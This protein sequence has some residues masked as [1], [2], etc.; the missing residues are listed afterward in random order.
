MKVTV[1]RTWEFTIQCASREV[2]EALGHP[3]GTFEVLDEDGDRWMF[4]TSVKDALADLQRHAETSDMYGG[5]IIIDTVG[6]FDSQ[7]K[8]QTS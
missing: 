8:R 5:E 3:R 4:T 6:E 2:C 1:T 7:I